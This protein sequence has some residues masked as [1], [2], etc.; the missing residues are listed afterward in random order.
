MKL[1]AKPSLPA[2]L[3]HGGKSQPQPPN[4]PG[5]DGSLAL[6]CCSSL[7]LPSSVYRMGHPCCHLSPRSNAPLGHLAVPKLGVQD[8]HG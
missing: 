5:S 7:L 3:L 8:G 2:S 6:Q 4:I 1:P